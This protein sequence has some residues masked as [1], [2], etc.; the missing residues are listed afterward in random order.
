MKTSNFALSQ[1]GRDGKRKGGEAQEFYF[2]PFQS[3]SAAALLVLTLCVNKTFKL[4]TYSIESVQYSP[5]LLAK[6]WLPPPSFFLER[7]FR[8]IS[9]KHAAPQLTFPRGEGGGGKK[10]LSSEIFWHSSTQLLFPHASEGEKNF[11]FVRR[12]AAEL[13]DARTQKNSDRVIKNDLSGRRRGRPPP[14]A[15]EEKSP[16]NKS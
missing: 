5:F 6:T 1:R 7:S 16:R 4:L 9:M 10:E 13:E 15:E 11:D 8:K 14:R 12:T 2:F 3:F